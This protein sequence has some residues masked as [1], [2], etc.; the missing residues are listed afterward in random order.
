MNLYLDGTSLHAGIWRADVWKG[1]WV[2]CEG[3]E[4]GKW[5][6]AAVVLRDAGEAVRPGK[7]ELYLDGRQAASGGAARL[8]YHPG[9]INIGRNGNTV[10]QDGPQDKA[11]TYFAGRIDDLRIYSRALSQAELAG[12][13]KAPE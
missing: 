6:S 4:A 11:G 7:I 2:S 13:A 10:F 1:T 5:H 3:I 8:T 9:D 12:M